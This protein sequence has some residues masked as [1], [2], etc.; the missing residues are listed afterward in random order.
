MQVYPYAKSISEGCG[1]VFM[2]R[3]QRT[4]SFTEE[5]AIFHR[6]GCVVQVLGLDIDMQYMRLLVAQ[7]TTIAYLC[8][9]D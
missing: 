3:N 6:C 1:F 8:E 9:G 7:L 4:W 2:V 5:T